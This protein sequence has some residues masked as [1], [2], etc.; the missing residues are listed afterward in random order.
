MKDSA[1]WIW[2]VG[3]L[4]GISASAAGLGGK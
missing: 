2:L 1:P 4:D 3:W